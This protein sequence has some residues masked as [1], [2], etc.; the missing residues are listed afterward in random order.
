MKTILTVL[1]IG[2]FGL[3]LFATAQIPDKLIYNG[4]EYNLNCNPL[5][6]YFENNPDKKPKGGISST[7]LWRGYVATFEIKDSL[8][9]VKDI[10]IEYWD[11]TK[12]NHDTKWKSVLNE[13]FPDQKEILVDWMTGL[14]VLPCGKV[15][16]YVHMGYGSTYENYILLE[17]Y[18]GRLKKEN[19][20]DYK[21]YEEFKERQFQAYKQ[22]EKHKQ[23][24]EELQKDGSSDEF[25]DS[26]LRGFVTDYTTKI[27][28]E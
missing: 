10:Q 25:I 28:T 15:V 3:N 8:L 14:L 24:K 20:Y 2:L 4:K 26:F 1:L 9:Y 16:N 19:H 5:E 17:I 27:L 13:V 11:T 12:K 6:S 22:T 23:I 7:A 18:S 21:E